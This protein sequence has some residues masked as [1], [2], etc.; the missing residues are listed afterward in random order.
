[1]PE[2]NINEPCTMNSLLHQLLSSQAS[3]HD[4][5]STK[6]VLQGFE[7]EL[8]WAAA[9]LYAATNDTS[10]LDDAQ[11]SNTRRFSATCIV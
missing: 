3:W 9:W 8:A 1:M 6:D 5:P 11:V 10:Y 7:D 4:A 2:D